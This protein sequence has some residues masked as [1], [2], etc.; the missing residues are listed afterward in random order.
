[1]DRLTEDNLNRHLET[2]GRELDE[3]RKEKKDCKAIQKE[4]SLTKKMTQVQRINDAL[5]Q[6]RTILRTEKE[7]QDI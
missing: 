4:R 6:I 7:K 3:L 5:F 1:M 2:F